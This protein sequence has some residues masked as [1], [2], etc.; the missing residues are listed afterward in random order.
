MLKNDS[1]RSGTSITS[2][3]D[4]G[5]KCETSEHFLLHCSLYHDIRKDIYEQLPDILNMS[6]DTRNYTISGSLLLAHEYEYISKRQNIF[7][8]DLLFEFLANTTRAL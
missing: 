1:Y 6:K 3:C 5:Y 4:C 7:I 8:K 2:V